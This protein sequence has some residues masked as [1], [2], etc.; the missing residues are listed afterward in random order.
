MS[1]PGF[2]IHFHSRKELILRYSETNSIEVLFQE[3]F[4]PYVMYRKI[5]TLSLPAPYETN[6]FDYRLKGHN[7]KEECIS[8]CRLKHLS[9]ILSKW[10][11]NYLSYNLSSNLFITNIY[12][13]F[14]AYNYNHSVDNEIGNRCRVECGKYIDCYQ[15]NFE[16]RLDRYHYFTDQ[17]YL[18]IQPPSL[19]DQIITHLPEMKFEE[20]ICFVGSLISL[21]FGF[22]VV[23]LSD[24]CFLLT[25]NLV[26]YFKNRFLVN[27]LL[28]Q[29][30]TIN[31]RAIKVAPLRSR[32]CPLHS[33][34]S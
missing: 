2:H 26:V 11:G 15:E 20:Y 9:L 29:N 25:K 12:D 13:N 33:S 34:L 28:Q 10:P 31:V 27:Q 18:L 24:I 7:S 23:M 22:S 8:R 19:P 17:L 21:W 5:K 3:G 32:S 4:T 6:C 16:L 1:V 30:I 14:Q